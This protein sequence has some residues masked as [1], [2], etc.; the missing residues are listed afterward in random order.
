MRKLHDLLKREGKKPRQPFERGVLV[1]EAQTII[2]GEQ[3][4]QR[5]IEEYPNKI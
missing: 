5:N 3:T 2:N 1:S 4:R